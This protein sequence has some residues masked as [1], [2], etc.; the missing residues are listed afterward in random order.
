MY[1]IQQHETEGKYHEYFEF[2]WWQ[3][4]NVLNALI[5]LLKVITSKKTVSNICSFKIPNSMIEIKET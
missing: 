2:V 1:E 3:F 4:W 5:E